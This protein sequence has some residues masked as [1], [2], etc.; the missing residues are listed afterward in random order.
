MAILIL[1]IIEKLLIIYFLLY[2]I[3]DI[4]LFVYSLFVFIRKKKHEPDLRDYSGHLV[5][6]IV[7]AYNEDAQKRGVTKVIQKDIRNYDE[8]A[9]QVVKLVGEMI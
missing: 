1:R 7:P 9:K 6:I 4:G 8:F 2:F 5:S 3:I